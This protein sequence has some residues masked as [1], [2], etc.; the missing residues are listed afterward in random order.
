MRNSDAIEESAYNGSV[1]HKSTN[2]ES[3]DTV[4]RIHS[5]ERQRGRE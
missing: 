1:D 3:V 5:I 2:H 4:V